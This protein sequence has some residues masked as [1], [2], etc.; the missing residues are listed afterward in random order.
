MN[1][2]KIGLGTHLGTFSDE[3]SRRYE[4]A[5]TFAIRNGITAVDTA[6]NYRGMRSERDVGA[7]VGALLASGEIRREDVFLATKAGLLF[8]DVVSGLNR[9]GVC[10]KYWSLGGSDG[11]T[12]VNMRGCTRR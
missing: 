9:Q 7:A 2:Y 8:G 10:R 12:S 3:D 4:E 6:I 1:M 11:M 5:V